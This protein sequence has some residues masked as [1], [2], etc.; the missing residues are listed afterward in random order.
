MRREAFERFCADFPRTRN[1]T[2]PPPP[3]RMY[4]LK[5]YHSSILLPIRGRM[6]AAVEILPEF[7]PQSA[8]NC[9]IHVIN[10]TIAPFHPGRRECTA[11]DFDEV[12][13]ARPI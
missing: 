9:G 2:A 12:S 1:R 7:Q 11:K 4:Q 10:N 13:S 3:H 8:S 5:L 6:H